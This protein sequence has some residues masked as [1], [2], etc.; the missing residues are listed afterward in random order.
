[1]IDSHVIEELKGRLGQV[2]GERWRLVEILGVGASAGVYR[3]EDERGWCVAVKVMHSRFLGSRIIR[4]RFLREQ[5][6]LDQV[7]HPHTLRVYET[8]QTEEGLPYIVMELLRGQTLARIMSKRGGVPLELERVAEY[9]AALLDALALC[10]GK[11][12]LHRDVKPANIFLTHEGVIKL[13]DFGV[14]RY[15]QDGTRLTRDGATLGTPSFM[16]PE[17]ASGQMNRLDER[18]DLFSLGATLYYLLSGQY[19]HQ[20]ETP[21]MTYLKAA[22]SPAPSLASVAPHLPEP[23]IALV[24]GALCWEQGARW[25]HAEAMSQALTLALKTLTPRPAPPPPLT[26]EGEFSLGLSA[27]PEASLSKL[28]NALIEAF[29]GAFETLCDALARRSPPGEPTLDVAASRCEAALRAVLQLADGSLHLVIFPFGFGQARA[30]APADL[31]EPRAP[32]LKLACY[33]LGASGVRGLTLSTHTTRRDLIALSAALA[34]AAR[35]EI[36]A[37]EDLATVLWTEPFAGVE[38]ELSSPFGRLEERAY[39]RLDRAFASHWDR[40]AE[41]IRSEFAL[42]AE[43]AQLLDDAGIPSSTERLIGR[44]DP[45]K[46]QLHSP[47]A[48]PLSPSEAL[49]PLSASRRLSAPLDV[50]ALGARHAHV[51]SFLLEVVQLIVLARRRGAEARV[52]DGEIAQL[53]ERYA[54]RFEPERRSVLYDGESVWVDGQLLCAER[55]LYVRA[56]RVMRALSRLNVYEVQFKAPLEAHDLKRLIDHLMRQRPLQRLEHALSPALRVRAELATPLG[57]WQP[58]RPA[59]ELSARSGAVMFAVLETFYA[60]AL[61]GRAPSLRHVTRAALHLVALTERSFSLALLSVPVRLSPSP[62]AVAIKSAVLCALIG[63]QLTENTRSIV[64]LIVSA[65]LYD[66]GLIA[67]LRA[68]SLTTSDHDATLFSWSAKPPARLKASLPDAAA[69]WLMDHGQQSEPSLAQSR[70]LSE[71]LRLEHHALGAERA[72]AIPIES[73]VLTICRRFARCL[74]ELSCTP[75]K[76]LSRVDLALDLT[77]QSLKSDRE[78]SVFDILLEVTGLMPRGQQ[79]LLSEGHHAVVM[80]N[81]ERPSCFTRPLISVVRSPTGEPLSPA[82]QVDLSLPSLSAT[83]WGQI[84][85]VIEEPR[86]ER[87]LPLSDDTITQIRRAPFDPERAPGSMLSWEEEETIT[88]G[89]SDHVGRLGADQIAHIIP[90]QALEALDQDVPQHTTLLPRALL[91]AFMS[92]DR[93]QRPGEETPARAILEDDTTPG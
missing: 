65:L 24:D 29:Y 70:C 85:D 60:E 26:R 18:S 22:T 5:T 2:I 16:S 21:Q 42:Q 53:C 8:S 82:V 56:L 73:F 80:A 81:H 54:D 6:I 90:L 14:A 48:L 10:H 83:A 64:N 86:E 34:S 40:I 36:K 55:D 37:S 25:Q 20:E 39:S 47:P 72:A 66:V 38:I 7:Q 28:P 67:P 61:C 75:P 27:R 4:Q 31:F 44:R 92:H 77:S 46:A 3:A 89:R 84:V 52:P 17:Q 12:I 41:T 43:R 79:V 33:L 1:M 93:Q 59:G 50:A 68:R 69:T 23:F 49:T 58:P 30:E 88:S 87:A 9:A 45:L 13:L 76:A 15:H 57:G 32:A 74:E 19:V 62:I 78:S 11:A 35:D 63:R 91:D 71:A 51:A